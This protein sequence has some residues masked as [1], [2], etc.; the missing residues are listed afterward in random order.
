MKISIIGGAGCVGSSAA[1]SIAIQGLADE[2]VVADIRQNVLENFFMDT[3]YAAV[4]H[5]KDLSIRM[6][7]HQDISGSDIVIIAAGVSVAA[8]AEAAESKG[9]AEGK[10]HSRQQLV[11]DNLAVI[12]EWAQAIN[13]FCSDAVVITVSNPVEVLNYAS[14]LL[15]GTK[16]RKRFIGYSLNDTIRF[17]HGVAQAIG[18][19]PSRVDCLAI[20]EHGDNQVL[21]FDTVRVDGQ[22]YALKEEIKQ[23]LRQKVKDHLKHMLSLKAGRSS[24]W[25]TGAGLAKMVKII[26]DDAREIVPACAALT[27]EYGYQGFS[28]GVPVVLGRQGIHKIIEL[29]LNQGE[30]EWLELSVNNL[31]EATR[32]VTDTLGMK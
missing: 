19:E 24:G 4:V 23:D 7:S 32:Y 17:R 30:K 9:A 31:K 25:L 21:L 8:K 1:L 18:V 28:M 22:P 6:G 29:E 16:D 20:G 15:S 5:Q 27:G 26:I 2:L 12:Q 10:I 11:A 3:E 14:Y 13:Q